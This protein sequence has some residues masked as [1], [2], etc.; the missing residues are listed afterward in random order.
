MIKQLTITIVIVITLICNFNTNKAVAMA[1]S[2]ATPHQLALIDAVITGNLSLIQQTI[3][4]QANV[5]TADIQGFTPLHHAACNNNLPIARLLLQAGASINPTNHNGDT[6]LALALH[7]QYTTMMLFLLNHGANTISPQDD[8]VAPEYSHNQTDHN[9]SKPKHD[10]QEVTTDSLTFNHYQLSYPRSGYQ[11][12]AQR[13]VQDRPISN[14]TKQRHL[15]YRYKQPSHIL[16]KSKLSIERHEVEKEQI[17]TSMLNKY[18]AQAQNLIH[19]VTNIDKQFADKLSE[20]LLTTHDND[21]KT[22]KKV[23]LSAQQKIRGT[24][25]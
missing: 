8:A 11:V 15:M 1:S 3:H 25:I 23:I 18:F 21:I 13:S 6:P 12:T 17:Q 5:N 4:S 9:I 20:Y 2:S 19:E 16:P 7:K 14:Q 10:T 22:V 24:N